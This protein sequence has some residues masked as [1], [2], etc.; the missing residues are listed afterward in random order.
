MITAFGVSNGTLQDLLTR[1]RT[2]LQQQC[3][4]IRRPQMRSLIEQVS[5]SLHIGAV[6]E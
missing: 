3:D 2:K 1:S 4:Q 5:I 6:F